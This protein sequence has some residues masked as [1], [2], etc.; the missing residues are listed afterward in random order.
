M[1]GKHSVEES[2]AFFRSLLFTGLKWVSLAGFAGLL[3]FGGW[4]LLGNGQN[5]KSQDD[6][7]IGSASDG[8]GSSEPSSSPSPP[9]E[10]LK[11]QVLSAIDDFEAM[12]QAKAKLVEAKYEIVTTGKAASN[13]EK[14]T[15]FFQPGAEEKAKAAAQVL[16]A[17]VTQ[18]APENLDKTIPITAVIGADFSG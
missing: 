12:E 6:P 10:P 7:R 8:E 18:P 13:Y 17:T 14:T 15:V 11:I 1:G 4:K 16:Q 9:P 5:E 3:I 2:G